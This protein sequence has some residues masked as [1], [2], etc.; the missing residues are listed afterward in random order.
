MVLPLLPPCFGS[1]ASCLNVDMGYVYAEARGPRGGRATTIGGETGRKGDQG[2]YVTRHFCSS[3]KNLVELFLLNFLS[4]FSYTF[5]CISHFCR[6]FFHHI[7]CRRETIDTFLKK[8]LLRFDRRARQGECST[9]LMVYPMPYRLAHGSGVSRLM[10]RL[11]PS[12]DVLKIYC[13]H[14]L[15][16]RGPCIILSL[17]LSLPAILRTAY[18]LH[19]PL[20][21]FVCSPKACLRF[22]LPVLCPNLWLC[23]VSFSR[24]SFNSE[25][26]LAASAATTKRGSKSREGQRNRRLGFSSA[27]LRSTRSVGWGKE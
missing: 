13:L 27:Y 5:L 8:C 24:G 19:H 17:I 12:L 1:H 14:D 25:S 7:R 10:P 22:Y 2:A 18:S 6:F 21:P 26:L 4:F 15:H 20:L 9:C 16:G 11:T 3:C 23:G